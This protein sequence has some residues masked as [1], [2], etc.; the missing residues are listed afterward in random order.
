MMRTR[1]RMFAILPLLAALIGSQAHAVDAYLPSPFADADLTLVD[2]VAMDEPAAK[3]L[4][5][6]YPAGASHTE[7]ILDRVTRV[8]PNDGTPSYFAYRLGR[9]L[10]LV[11]GQ[12]YLLRVEYPEDQSRSVIVRNYGAEITRGFHTGIALGDAMG[13]FA[14]QNAES[15]QLPLSGRV[16]R[17]E[18]LFYLHSQFSDLKLPRDVGGR[19]MQPA[20]GFWVAIGRFDARM[21]AG[22]AGAAVASIKLYK[23]NNAANYEQPLNLPPS[24]LPRRHLFWRQ[25]MLDS[26]VQSADPADNGLPRLDWFEFKARIL[27]FLGMNTFTTDMLEF[28]YDQGFDATPWGGNDWYYGTQF[29]ADWPEVLDRATAHGLDVLP[30]YEYAGSIGAASY[31]KERTAEPLYAGPQAPYT[32]ISWSEIAN[33][34][35]MDPAALVDVQHLLD[36]TIAMQT[37]HAQ[38]AGAWLRT[39]PSHLPISFSDT[40]RAR[41]ADE[42]NG[43]A[44]VSKAQ[45]QSDS[46]LHGR[47]VDWWLLKRRDF[48]VS[49]RDYVRQ[50]VG[51]DAFV[52]FTADPSEGGQNFDVDNNFIVTDDP[53]G[54]HQRLT[55]LGG[56]YVWW[57]SWDIDQVVA[58]DDHLMAITEQRANTGSQNEWGHSTPAADPQNYANTGGVFQSFDINR[59]YTVA[60]ANAFAQFDGP[61]GVA[62]VRHYTLNE[63]ML[64]TTGN[65][66]TDMANLPLGY[67]VADFER[68]GPYSMMAE[69][70]AVANGN[71]TLVGYLCSNLMTRG[72]PAYARRFD[73]AYLALP[74][75]PSTRLDGAASDANIAVQRIATPSD[76]IYYAVVNTSDASIANATIT[77][78]ESGTIEDA[79][80]GQTL[81]GAGQQLALSM[82]PYELRSFRVRSASDA[83]FAN[84][85][86]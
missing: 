5:Q 77:F 59:K 13:G 37:T 40:A 32:W 52:L 34:D 55:A 84:G 25:E 81:L 31:G 4:L 78:V 35:V 65:P 2:E 24:G 28:G 58:D 27:K 1:R 22:S 64:S 33:A 70:L 83:I 63:D 76:G 54:W 62:V 73:A 75:L 16:E 23:V 44:A 47:Y 80:T 67:F 39:R 50:A 82:Y 26:V 38:F 3:H 72:F 7:T 15:L 86:D 79:A 74:A 68:A 42:A 8:L 43:G 57:R 66:E 20:D 19:T 18:S 51:N 14:Q 36:V 69:A 46:A 53:D 21:D 48:L 45:L 11:P 9:N 29:P 41:F 71:P 60:S 10:G 85:F 6:E 56:N 61:G 17:W 30:Y 12:A 49:I